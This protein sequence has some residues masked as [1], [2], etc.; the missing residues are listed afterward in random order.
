MF[1]FTMAVALA[2][3]LAGC[4]LVVSGPSYLGIGCFTDHAAAQRTSTAPG[5]VDVIDVEGVGLLMARHGVFLG[6]VDQEAVFAAPGADVH[7]RLSDSE[8][9]FG[10]AAERWARQWL[11]T[12]DELA[13][14]RNGDQEEHR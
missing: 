5:D 9:A 12:M 7:C 1:L 2:L 8:V 10:P 4:Q 14:E 6:Y 13:M 3:C 11:R